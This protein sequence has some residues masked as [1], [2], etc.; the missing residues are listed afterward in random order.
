MIET[1]SMLLKN[2]RVAETLRLRQTILGHPL[3]LSAYL[4]K[5]VQR[6]LKYRL[7]LEVTFKLSFSFLTLF[8]A[9]R[10]LLITRSVDDFI[11][12][13]PE[14]SFILLEVIITFSHEII[15]S[16]NVSLTRRTSR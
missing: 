15:P 5:P 14:D 3:P 1:L 11:G 13:V 10:Y 2:K 4:L 7:F 12:N 6:V 9:M 16:G 8:F